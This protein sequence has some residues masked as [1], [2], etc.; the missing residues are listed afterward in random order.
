MQRIVTLVALCAIFQAAVQSRGDDQPDQPATLARQILRDT[1]RQ[2]LVNM[3]MIEVSSTR[4]REAGLDFPEVT[5]SLLIKADDD[6]SSADHSH[7]PG[8][9]GVVNP[10]HPLFAFLD[11]LQK[12]GLA[13]TLAE[14][15]LITVSGRE[16]YFA[17]GGQ[18]PILQQRVNGKLSTEFAKYGSEVNLKP[19]DLGGGRIRL[20]VKPRFAEL[21]K[22]LE[23]SSGGRTVPGL[24]VHEFQATCELASGETMVMR[25][26]TNK[27]I[28]TQGKGNRVNEDF[29]EMQMLVLVTPRLIDPPAAKDAKSAPNRAN[30][31]F[32]SSEDQ[33][34]GL[35]TR[36]TGDDSG[37]QLAGRV[38]GK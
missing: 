2:V 29:V 15:A 4:M 33:Q 17:S 25:M 19:E 7:I 3:R 24:N 5:R 28:S 35:H 13:K 14:P 6:R 18:V 30:D 9:L 1:K 16:A 32:G 11:D 10:G 8:L 27:V 22:S 12:K 20:N 31:H 21:D 37:G 26:T 38:G 36:P 34:S 23:I